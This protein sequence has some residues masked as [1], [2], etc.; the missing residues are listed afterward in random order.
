MNLSNLNYNYFTRELND[1]TDIT[2]TYIDSEGSTNLY[3]AY[4]QAK[5]KFSDK[6][7]ASAGLHYTHFELSQDNSLEP[8]LGLTIQLPK[9]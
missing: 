5:Y 4:A 9:L 8:R 1:S 3:Q 2:N 6:V 7:T